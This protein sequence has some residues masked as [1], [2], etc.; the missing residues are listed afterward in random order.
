MNAPWLPLL[1]SAL[2]LA[3]LWLIR[4]LWLNGQEPPLP[5]WINYVLNGL[6]IALLA[7]IAWFGVEIM[8][9]NP[10]T[11]A[12][13]IAV[14]PLPVGQVLEQ[15]DVVAQRRP[16]ES[17]IAR[18][19]ATPTASPT[20]TPTTDPAATATLTAEPKMTAT[21]TASPTSTVT[22]D[23]AATATSTPAPTNTPDC[24][25]CSPDALKTPIPASVSIVGRRV[26]RAIAPGCPVTQ[27]HLEPLV[28]AVIPLQMIRSDT[29][30][31]TGSLLTVTQL[32][33]TQVPPKAIV[34]IAEVQNKIA[35]T[36]L[37]AGVAITSGQLNI[38]LP[39]PASV[40]TAAAVS[41]TALGAYHMMTAAD[42]TISDTV[43]LTSAEKAV[44]TP[45]NYIVL[46][47]I[48]QGEPIL[49]SQ[50]V[51]APDDF[52]SPVY[53]AALLIHGPQVF[54]DTFKP[55]DL[56]DLYVTQRVIT[57]TEGTP[58]VLPVSAQ[59]ELPKLEGALVLAIKTGKDSHEVVLAVSKEKAGELRNLLALA[60]QVEYVLVRRGRE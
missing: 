15:D 39:A 12:V 6:T 3:A 13:W 47:P 48:A 14:S 31:G 53:V 36:D 22:T 1:I 10:D 59:A 33:A 43:K 26:V 5:S 27:G 24:A 30:I 54:Y 29:E 34:S 25:P 41:T 7:L 56:V 20:P 11:D 21:P 60:H 19:A 23:P 51:K 28:P 49:K 58:H 32:L 50:V 2:L 9:R 42:Y 45:T 40:I 57:D 35:K 44:S 55:G 4:L 37:M 52:K 18:C 38:P 8:Q 46:T 16:D 17:S